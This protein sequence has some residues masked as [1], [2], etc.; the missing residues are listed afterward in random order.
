[1]ADLLAQGTEQLSEALRCIRA[2]PEAASKRADGATHCARQ[3][4]K[5]YR[6]AV[7]ALR[8]REE[9]DTLS[10]MTTFEAYRSQLVIADAVV[11]VAHRIWYSVL[12][13]T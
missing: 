2:D 11:H 13:S 9:Q 6:A 1:M 10:L 12:R 4:E 3:V 7:V 5:A 8:T